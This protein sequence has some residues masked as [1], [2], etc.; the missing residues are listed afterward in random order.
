MKDPLLEAL[1]TIGNLQDIAVE[2]RKRGEEVTTGSKL[3]TVI[4]LLFR[5]AQEI[6]D[7]HCVEE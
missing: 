6:T 5:E 1:C 4:E 3:A 2:L 7:D